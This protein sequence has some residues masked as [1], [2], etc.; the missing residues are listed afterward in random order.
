MLKRLLTSLITLTAILVV[1]SSSAAA[2]RSCP[3]SD[4]FLQQLRATNIG[5]GAANRVMFGWARASSCFRG[6]SGLLADRVRPCSVLRYRCVAHR[7][8][9]GV[10]VRC[11]RGTRALRFFDS[12]G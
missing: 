12:Q 9:G 10:T 11:Q 6:G 4:R 2:T 7:A 1:V 8:T 3:P 5:C